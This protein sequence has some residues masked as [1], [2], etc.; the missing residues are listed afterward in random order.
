MVVLHVSFVLVISETVGAAL[1]KVI[2]VVVAL[3][4]LKLP[5][6]LL[7]AVALTI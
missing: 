5:V 1:S 3:V 6:L 7:Y 4:K 2:A